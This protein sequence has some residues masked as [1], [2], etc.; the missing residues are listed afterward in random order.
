MMGESI[1]KMQRIKSRRNLDKLFALMEANRNLPVVFKINNMA[2]ESDN[3]WNLGECED[4]YIGE[5]TIVDDKVCEDREV[6]K[7]IYYK[8][9]YDKICK[10]F[11][12]KKDSE[13]E[14]Y[15]NTQAN[16]FFAKS[17]IVVIEKCEENT[18]LS[19]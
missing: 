18:I 9:H 6:F 2:I 17:I 10:E 11:K 7:K 8:K 19:I 12:N 13:L 1:I 5:C 4:C 15:L 3:Y 14:E 16:Y